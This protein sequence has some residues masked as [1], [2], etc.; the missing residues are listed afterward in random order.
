MNVGLHDQRAGL[1][2]V[3]RHITKFGGDPDNVSIYRESAGGASMVMQV[4]FFMTIVGIM[5]SNS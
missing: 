5:D 3:Q 4:S 1:E 2:W